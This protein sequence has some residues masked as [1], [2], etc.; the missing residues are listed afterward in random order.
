MIYSRDMKPDEFQIASAKRRR[1]FREITYE[2]GYCKKKEEIRMPSADEYMLALADLVVDHPALMNYLFTK[3]K[4]EA[5]R[6]L[7]ALM[8]KKRKRER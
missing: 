2:R 8:K 6:V 5:L 7:R 4:A 3:S 1:N